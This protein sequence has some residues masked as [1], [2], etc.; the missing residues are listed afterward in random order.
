MN[1][2]V[3]ALEFTEQDKLLLFT[4]ELS[5]STC[6]REKVSHIL[7][8]AN[9]TALV[10][11]ENYKL[12][13]IHKLCFQHSVP[14]DGM[15]GKRVRFDVLLPQSPKLADIILGSYK[16]T[17]ATVDKEGALHRAPPAIKHASFIN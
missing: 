3:D 16:V 10:H 2:E 11:I 12:R 14:V 5:L 15:I 13:I 6:A 1:L 17:T 4:V 9:L 8:A 7:L